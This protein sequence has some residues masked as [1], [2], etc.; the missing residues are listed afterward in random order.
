MLAVCLATLPFTTHDCCRQ[1]LGVAAEVRHQFVTPPS[2]FLPWANLWVEAVNGGLVVAG[3]KFGRPEFR[4]S[5]ATDP[6][7]FDDHPPFL[8]RVLATK[9]I[10]EVTSRS[11]PDLASVV[12]GKGLIMVVRGL[13]ANFP[14]DLRLPQIRAGHGHAQP[15]SSCRELACFSLARA[16]LC[17]SHL[18]P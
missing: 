13:Y 17:S 15:S 1:P 10:F 8:A 12:P 5:V 11:A 4:Q 6:S 2:L 9:A 3:P 14:A 7:E 18:W 16:K